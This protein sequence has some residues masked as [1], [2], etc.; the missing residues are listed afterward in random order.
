M[1]L[2]LLSSRR[3]IWL[4]SDFK[5][6]PGQCARVL[7][8]GTESAWRRSSTRVM[9]VRTHRTASPGG[10]EGHAQRII[11]FAAQNPSMIESSSALSSAI[12]IHAGPSSPKFP[13]TR[14]SSAAAWQHKCKRPPTR[15]ASL[16]WTG[17]LDWESGKLLQ[18]VSDAIRRPFYGGASGLHGDDDRDR[19]SSSDETIELVAKIIEDVTKAVIRQRKISAALETN[20]THFAPSHADAWRG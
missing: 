14:S 11:E 8:S 19:N 9:R 16:I 20:N 10:V 2:P 15:A 7:F 17:S 12:S 3:A 6:S 13:S 1:S 18:R 5:L 4:G